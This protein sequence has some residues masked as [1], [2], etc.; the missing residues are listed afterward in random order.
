MKEWGWWWRGACDTAHDL[1]QLICAPAPAGVSMHDGPRRCRIAAC[2]RRR[3]LANSLI[4]LLRR[5]LAGM[6][7]LAGRAT[8]QHVL[9]TICGPPLCSRSPG[10]CRTGTP[11]ARSARSTLYARGLPTTRDTAAE[12]AASRAAGS[13]SRSLQM[14]HSLAE[15]A[16]TR[17]E[18]RRV[19]H[20]P[21]ATPR[22]TCGE[23]RR[24][25]WWQAPPRRSRSRRQ[26]QSTRALARARAAP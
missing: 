10:P 26:R 19:P 15:N 9:S 24:G 1:L 21:M 3:T 18:P 22:T 7:G 23:E 14:H 12:L 13:A 11:P 17:S 2:P 8:V 25:S 5:G 20:H 6:I 4:Y 16:A